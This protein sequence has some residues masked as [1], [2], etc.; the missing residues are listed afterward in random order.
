M[1]HKIKKAFAD[2]FGES[3]GLRVF[4]APGRVNLIGELTGPA[5]RRR[6][7]EK[8]TFTRRISEREN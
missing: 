2:V 1:K 4:F 8:L 7:G 6:Q 5:M 3:E